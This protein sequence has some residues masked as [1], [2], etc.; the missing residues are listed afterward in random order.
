MRLFY[1]IN[2]AEGRPTGAGSPVSQPEVEALGEAARIRR[3]LSVC[4]SFLWK[5]VAPSRRSEAGCN[6]DDWKSCL[7]A[8]KVKALFSGI[9]WITQCPTNGRTDASAIMFIRRLSDRTFLAILFY[10]NRMANWCWCN[11]HL[12]CLYMDPLIWFVNTVE[13]GYGHPIRSTQW[14]DFNQSMATTEIHQTVWN[15]KWCGNL[16]R[17]KDARNKWGLITQRHFF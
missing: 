1:T 13:Y 8:L 4:K 11:D 17:M 5:Q 9:E 3:L 16:S 6:L 12:C 7:R 14:W 2:R 10:L 15:G